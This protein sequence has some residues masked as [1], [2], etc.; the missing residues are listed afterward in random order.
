M[1]TTMTLRISELG[2]HWSRKIKPSLNVLFDLRLTGLKFLAHGL[3]AS[4]SSSLTGKQSSGTTGQSSWIFS[5]L[6]QRIPSWP[7]HSMYKFATSIPRS[8]FIL[9]T[10]LNSI[11]HF[12]RKCSPQL[13]QI[14]HVQT[15]GPSLLKRQLLLATRNAWMCLAAIGALAPAKLRSV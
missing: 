11:Y 9:M 2:M 14:P 3:Q 1:I 12:L 13:L 10:E 6:C 7:Y 15:R 4:L 5:G 8:P